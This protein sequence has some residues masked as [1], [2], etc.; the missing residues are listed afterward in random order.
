MFL[1]E[2]AIVIAM[3]YMYVAGP[4]RGV[5]RPHESRVMLTKQP[6]RSRR[7]RSPWREWFQHVDGTKLQGLAMGLLL[8]V[9][10]IPTIKETKREVLIVWIARAVAFTLAIVALVLTTKNFCELQHRGFGESG[11]EEGGVAN[12]EQAVS[13]GRELVGLDNYGQILTPTL[14]TQRIQ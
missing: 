10:L 3:G 7:S 6:L 1:L 11:V 13:D 2:F 5:Q 9:L 12:S 4:L 8:A 14:Q